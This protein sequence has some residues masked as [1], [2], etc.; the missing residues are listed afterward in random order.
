M[1]MNYDYFIKKNLIFVLVIFSPFILSYLLP[2]FFIGKRYSNF[3][4]GGASAIINYKGLLSILPIIIFSFTSYFS[5]FYFKRLYNECESTYFNK[6]LINVLIVI[7]TISLT[8]HLD[9]FIKFPSFVIQIF[10]PLTY[11]PLVSLAILKNNLSKKNYFFYFIIAVDCSLSFISDSFTRDI[12]TKILILILINKFKKIK[13][14]D[15]IIFFLFISLVF[16]SKDL[17]RNSYLKIDSV[18]L[19]DFT[20]DQKLAEEYNKKIDLSNKFLSNQF[21]INNTKEI[22]FYEIYK[23][24]MNKIKKNPDTYLNELHLENF[25][26]MHS[27]CSVRDQNCLTFRE[28]YKRI[29]NNSLK[30]TPN[31]KKVNF[32]LFSSLDRFNKIP[33]LIFYYQFFYDKDNL[34]LKNKLYYPQV[35]SAIPIPRFIWETKPINANGYLIGDIFNFNTFKSGYNAWYEPLLIELFICFGLLGLF[36]YFMINLIT[37]YTIFKLKFSIKDL[38]GSIFLIGIIKFYLDYHV[39]GLIES[40]GGLVYFLTVLL[41]CERI[42]SFIKKSNWLRG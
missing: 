27:L 6:N 2:M 33:N 17:L 18:S 13:I 42:L 26:D 4:I 9:N 1:R 29:I 37:I 41:V 7:S 25:Y 3:E 36:F 22:E 38:R 24:Y 8:S 32:S 11:L 39:Q 34:F 14:R 23:E 28:F 20:I 30:K 40:I 5:V 35:F 15:L 16:F 31:D 19:S 12:L 10:I 21:I